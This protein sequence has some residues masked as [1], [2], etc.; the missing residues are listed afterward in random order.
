MNIF[1]KNFC[2]TQI[3][4]NGQ[5]K[6]SPRKQKIT[7]CEK[8][9]CVTLKVGYVMEVDLSSHDCDKLPGL[10]GS[11]SARLRMATDANG[12]GRGF[13]FAR[14][15][16]STQAGDVIV[17]RMRGITN[18]GTHRE[19]EKC[20]KQ[21]HLEG[22]L[23]GK[24]IEGEHKGC[25]VRASY[26]IDYDSGVEPQDSANRMAIEGVLLCPCKDEK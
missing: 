7:T 13:H 4:K 17:G 18:A 10:D 9:D 19:C 6:M 25:R 14:Y 11:L 22:V 12:Q 24:V 5:G 26:V 8:S 20:D 16:W 2:L 15:R 21:G 23:N 3:S 1:K